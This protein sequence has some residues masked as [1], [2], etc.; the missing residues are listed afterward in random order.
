MSHLLTANSLT[1]LLVAAILGGV[2]VLIVAK[3]VPGFQLK[4]GLG[5]AIAVAVVYGVLKAVLQRLL[6]LVSLPLVLLT[7][8]IF[9][10]IINAFILWLTSVLLSNF[11]VKSKTALV[12]GAFLLAVIDWLFTFFVQHGAIY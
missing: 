2:A 3:I 7:L 11:E 4:G 1:Q 5:S 8:G 6:I 10:L 9:I 12:V